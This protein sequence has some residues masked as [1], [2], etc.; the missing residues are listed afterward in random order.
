MLTRLKLSIFL[1]TLLPGLSFGGPLDCDPSETPIPFDPLAPLDLE[2]SNSEGVDL[3]GIQAGFLSDKCYDDYSLTKFDIYLPQADSPTPLIIYIHGG[4]FVN[5]D[6]RENIQDYEIRAALRNG[7]AWAS[8]NY[9]LLLDHGDETEGVNK[10][11]FDSKRA[12]QYLRFKA[13]ELNI[14][15]NRV[16]IY[17]ASAG[18][19]TALWLAFNDDMSDESSEDP[20]MRESTRVTA[21]AAR[22]TQASYDIGRWE[23]DVFIDFDIT[24]PDII[25][26]EPEMEG[27]LLAL[28]G[29]DETLDEMESS[30]ILES[31]E[32][33]EYR[34][35]VDMLSLVTP[36]DPPACLEQLVEDISAP[37][38]IGTLYHHAFHT[39]EVL[40]RVES[41]GIENVADIPGLGINSEETRIHFLL[42]HLQ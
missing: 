26:A 3:E 20:V 6:K 8:I 41:V 38:D 31:S 40:E 13:Q 10:S 12:L 35:E 17:G 19:G 18:A 21:V 27:R 36:D 25:R 23:S 9:R 33:L 32:I 30:G 16:A 29:V 5:G 14:D 39:R 1:L 4:G 22:S 24:I 42:R 37:S 2:F 11:L 15:T 7:V 34:A 28:Y